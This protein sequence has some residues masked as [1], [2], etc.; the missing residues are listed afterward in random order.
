VLVSIEPATASERLVPWVRVLAR[1]SGAIVH[2]LT[3]CPPVRHLIAAP[4]RT[5]AYVNR[6]EEAA[7]GEALARLCRV[8]GRLD[9]DG[10]C[11]R[12]AVRFGDP[13]ESI[14]AAA[15]ECAAGLIAVALRR[16]RDGVAAFWR[17]NLATT[18]LARTPVPVLIVR[19]GQR[20]A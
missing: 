14:L 8:A 13:V 20:A 7:R 3:V 11:T 6:I 16:G 15:R 18:L 12:V 19:P 2:L 10:V 17:S 1:R 9:A 4:G 5:V